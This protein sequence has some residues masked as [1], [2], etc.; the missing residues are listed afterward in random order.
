MS[1]FCVLTTDTPNKPEVAEIAARL[2]VDCDAA[3]G[4]LV[5]FWCWLSSHA[6]DG[7]LPT[8]SEAFIARLTHSADFVNALIACGW[9]ERR[10]GRLIA[11]GFERYNARRIFGAERVRRWRER[12]AETPAQSSPLPPDAERPSLAEVL[13]LAKLRGV[14]EAEARRF[15]EYHEGNNLW[16]NRHGHAINWKAKLVSWATRAREQGH[17]AQS[18]TGAEI[19]LRTRELERVEKELDTIRSQYDS[20]ET[21]SQQDRARAKELRARRDELR[22]LLNLTA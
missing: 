2:K 5:R 6:P 11:R 15:F 20:H 22:K 3:L 13:E 10:D 1:R 19:V 9:L 17:R 18:L 16:Q 12:H 21:M 8:S 14:T 7:E 4:K